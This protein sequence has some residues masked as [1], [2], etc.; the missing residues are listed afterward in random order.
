MDKVQVYTI[1]LLI[2]SSVTTY[3]PALVVPDYAGK[4][5]T[6]VQAAVVYPLKLCVWL[7]LV[8]RIFNWW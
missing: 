6:S 3:L 4:P 2:V 5:M 7:P 8:G 1:W